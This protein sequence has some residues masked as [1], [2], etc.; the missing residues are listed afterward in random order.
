MAVTKLTCGGRRDNK[1]GVLEIAK[2][3]GLMAKA[4]WITWTDRT[5]SFIK[6]LM[7]NAI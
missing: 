4:I 6:M 2:L 5:H 7:T 1:M 3:L